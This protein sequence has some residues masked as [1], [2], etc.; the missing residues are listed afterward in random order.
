MSGVLGGLI[1]KPTAGFSPEAQAVIDRM[2][3]LTAGEKNAI[4]VFVDAEVI[5][6]N[7]AL[8]DE[9]WCFGLTTEANAL[10]GWFAKTATNNGAT[11]VSTGFS[12]NGTTDYVDSNFNL[13]TDGVKYT[14]NDALLG[15][16]L[17][18]HTVDGMMFG[19]RSGSDFARMHTVGT[20]MIVNS[21]GNRSGLDTENRELSV[22]IRDSS[23]NTDHYIDG[24]LAASPATQTST[25]IPNN[26]NYIGCY[27]NQGSPDIFL[28]GI[29]SSFIVGSA[30]GFDHSSHNTNLNAL[31]TSLG[32][33]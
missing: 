13:N 22:I 19:A 26:N 21:D 6:G 5:N 3:G 18:E 8:I 14:L 16:Y 27:N 31:L 30:I 2:T 15:C 25:A 20:A 28:N 29:I 11:K 10:K 1:L 24:V 4:A 33:I 32:V 17:Y 9:F 23:T 12:F 7:W